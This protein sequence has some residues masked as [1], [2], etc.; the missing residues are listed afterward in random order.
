MKSSI[1]TDN[2]KRYTCMV[3]FCVFCEE[4]PYMMKTVVNRFKLILFRSNLFS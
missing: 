3:D 1:I 2:K 4:I